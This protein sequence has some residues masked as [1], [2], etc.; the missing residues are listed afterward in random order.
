[1]PR[2]KNF[3]SLQELEERT[4]MRKAL[5]VIAIEVR[6]AHAAADRGESV[7]PQL[8]AIRTQVTDL[9]KAGLI[10]TPCTTLPSGTEPSADG[11]YELFECSDELDV[12]IADLQYLARTGEEVRSDARR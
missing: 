11:T 9:A 1:M 7:V 6:A 12:L 2:D 3:I 8:D 4:R 5:E 10:K